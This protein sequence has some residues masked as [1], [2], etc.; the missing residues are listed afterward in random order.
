MPRCT[1]LFR[2]KADLQAALAELPAGPGIYRFYDASDGLIYIGKSV[3]LKD[4]VRSYFT[5]KA[6]CKK[7]RRLRQEIARLDFETTGSELE[8]LLLESRLV[9]RHQPRF[10]VMLRGV[11]VLPYVRV[12]FRDPFPRLE[13]TRAPARDGAVYFGPFRSGEALDVAVGS[14]ADALQ[15]RDCNHPGERLVGQKPCY[16]HEFQTCSAPCLGIIDSEKYGQAVE[17]AAGV[18]AGREEAALEVLQRRMERAAE[19]LQ[20]EIAARLRDA[21]RHIRSVAGKQHALFSAVNDLS[22]VAACPSRKKDSLCLFL[23]R[24]GRLVL[25]EDAPLDLLRHPGARRDWA[26]RLV[27]YPAPKVETE[28]GKLDPALLDEIQI[29][30]AWMKQ[31]TREGEYWLIPRDASVRDATAGLSAW[32]AGQVAAPEVRL[33]LADAA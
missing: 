24:S 32:L 6:D 3:C 19:R 10:N 8:A 28:S 30:T 26:E 23:I 11:V 22:L 13:I 31:K 2:R 25:Q 33:R 5:G 14:L 9:K 18:F 27:T 12:D 16:R 1:A 21:V 4:R 7:V 15:L 29:V 20:F 17:K